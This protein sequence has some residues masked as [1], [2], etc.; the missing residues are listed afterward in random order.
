MDSPG[1]GGRRDLPPIAEEHRRTQQS[2]C[3]HGP[4]T[5]PPFMEDAPGRADPG[6]GHRAFRHASV[7]LLPDEQ[8]LASAAV[9]AQMDLTSTTFLRNFAEKKQQRNRIF[10]TL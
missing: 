4:T 5:G 8:S 9:V 10:L 3:R 7:R 6:R 1:P 2:H